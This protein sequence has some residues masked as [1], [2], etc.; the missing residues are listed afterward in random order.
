MTDDE[1]GAGSRGPGAAGGTGGAGPGGTE[2]DELRP[3]APDSARLAWLR[4]RLAGD[5]RQ[6]GYDL[7][8]FRRVRGLSDAELA[9][10]LG[11]D[12]DGLARL[13]LSG[14][15]REDQYNADV[16]AIA[17]RHGVGDFT[18]RRLLA[19][20]R[21]D[22]ALTASPLVGRA[23]A[24]ARDHDGELERPDRA[25]AEDRPGYDGTRDVAS[26][27][28]PSDPATERPDGGPAP[29]GTD[30]PRGSDRVGPERTEPER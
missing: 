2:G 4:R 7:E 6:L 12:L 20:V 28:T 25:V 24:A 23:L 29:D 18:L 3:A 21:N 22:A 26:P 11:T 1:I 30:T 19:V 15:P 13:S 16:R 9:A 5:R 17:Q 10:H 14:R 27:A 8:R